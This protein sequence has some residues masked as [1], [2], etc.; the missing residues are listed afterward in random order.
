MDPVDARDRDDRRPTPV[1][2]VAAPQACRPRVGAVGTLPR[3]PPGTSSLG[4][5]LAA[6]A[7]SGAEKATSAAVHTTAVRRAGLAQERI[8]AKSAKRVTQQ[9]LRCRTPRNSQLNKTAGMTVA[10]QDCLS[11]G[12]DALARRTVCLELGCR[13]VAQRFGIATPSR[14][15]YPAGS[16]RCSDPPGITDSNLNSESS[17][18]R[19][20]VALRPNDLEDPVHVELKALQRRPL[21]ATDPQSQKSW[22]LFPRC[23]VR[24]ILGTARQL[25]LQ[26]TTVHQ[27]LLLTSD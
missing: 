5:L 23:S 17:N 7:P 14:A 4:A 25:R 24:M 3:R 11:L 15:W 26:A 10:G 13:A 22:S 18:S 27:L 2:S 12:R 19:R 20:I 16:L 21:I 8:G 9:R 6:P 1:R